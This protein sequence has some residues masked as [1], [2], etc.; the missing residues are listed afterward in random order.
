M[1]PYKVLE[2][3]KNFTKKELK[4]SYKRLVI[5][6]HPDLTASVKTT[7]IFQ[8]LTEAYNTL[9]IELEKRELEPQHHELKSRFRDTTK[10]KNGKTSASINL[11][12]KF[13]INRFN[14]IFDKN[15][16]KDD[17]I[18]HGYEEWLQKDSKEDQ[19]MEKALVNYKEPS[20]MESAMATRFYS[21]GVDKVSDYSNLADKSLQF[22]D[23]KK[24]LTTTRIVDSSKVEKRREFKSLNDIKKH[25]AK[26][27]YNMTP[28]EI[29][30]YHKELAKE[31]KKE[32]KRVLKQ[33]LK[34]DLIEKN[35]NRS[36]KLFLD[37]S[38]N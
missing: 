6:Y 35:Y 23:L 31:K 4:A 28:E 8:A 34:D 26:L 32:A 5:K 7:P 13:D 10:V 14:E 1:D 17:Y 19:N 24:A 27:D 15:K 9:L 20:P 37:L 2:L 16:F 25:R 33:S 11:N 22:M 38:S 3:P 30:K 18:D 36:N 29:E 21:L 12:K